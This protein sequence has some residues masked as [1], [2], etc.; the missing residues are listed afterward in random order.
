[1][2]LLMLIEKEQ[3]EICMYINYDKEEEIFYN[4]YYIKEFKVVIKTPMAANHSS[5]KELKIEEFNLVN[6]AYLLK[7]D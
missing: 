5:K 4:N 7:I 6:S 1:M 2:E 3:L